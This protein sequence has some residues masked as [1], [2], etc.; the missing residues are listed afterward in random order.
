MKLIQ[1]FKG[2]FAEIPHISWPTRRQTIIL[3][4]IVILV[5]IA[6]GYFLGLF[7]LI[8]TALLEMVI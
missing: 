8:F 2:V 5:S 6:A 4:I 1:Y 7:D 3:T